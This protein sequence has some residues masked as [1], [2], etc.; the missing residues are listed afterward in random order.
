MLES[1]D[2]FNLRRFADRQRTTYRTALKEVQAGQKKSHWMWFIFPTP[3]HVENGVE[4]GSPK[5]QFFAIRSDEEASAFL[6]FEEEGVKL[7]EN[8]LEI[9]R[10]VLQKV[11][12]GISLEALFGDDE[13]KLK[14]S[15]EFF[16]RVAQ[17]SGDQEVQVVCKE[18]LQESTASGSP[19]SN[20]GSEVPMCPACS[21]Q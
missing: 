12:L 13:K 10:V 9:S 7:R 8:Y 1:D 18:V 15:L 4:C 17:H 21:V 11:K 14:S 20:C 16:L 6:N 2:P 19:M 3:P 5:N